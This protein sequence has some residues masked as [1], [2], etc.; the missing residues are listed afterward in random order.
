[1]KVYTRTPIALHWLKVN[2]LIGLLLTGGRIMGIHDARFLPS[3][4]A[5]AVHVYGDPFCG[6]GFLSGSRVLPQTIFLE[7]DKAEPEDLD[8]KPRPLRVDRNWSLT[9]VQS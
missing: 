9:R 1:M 4:H 2:S 5:R 6:R 8:G 7:T 3:L